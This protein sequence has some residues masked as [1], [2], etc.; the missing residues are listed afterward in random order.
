L[1]TAGD[2]LATT[3]D[4][5]KGSVAH[6]GSLGDRQTDRNNLDGQAILVNAIL[7]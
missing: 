6:S 7:S 5:K 4:K 1:A 3:T 2:C